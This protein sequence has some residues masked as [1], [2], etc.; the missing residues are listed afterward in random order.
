M[1][2]LF[3]MELMVITFLGDGFGELLLVLAAQVSTLI[4]I[5]SA[6]FYVFWTVVPPIY[7]NNINFL[8]VD[9]VLL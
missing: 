7:M 1:W 2:E 3:Y 4:W 6:L 9:F 5:Q 8:E